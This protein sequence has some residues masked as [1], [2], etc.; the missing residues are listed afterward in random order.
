MTWIEQLPANYVKCRSLRHAWDP[1]EF[2]RVDLEEI[3]NY[4]VPR[5]YTQVVKREV[6]CMRCG[7]VRLELFGRSQEVLKDFERFTAAYHYPEKYLWDKD[8]DETRP[9]FRDAN[10]ELFRRLSHGV[11]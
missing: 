8:V 4:M 2:R 7:V 3:A 6:T 1:T 11:S 9:T 5:Q 10:R